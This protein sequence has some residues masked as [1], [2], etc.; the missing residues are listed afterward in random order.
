[1]TVPI[2]MNTTYNTGNRTV[3][4]NRLAAFFVKKKVGT[5]CNLEV[6]YVGAPLAVP[7]GTYTPGQSQMSELSIPVLYK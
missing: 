4:S 6:E 2:A 7:E 3:V 1:I 5:N